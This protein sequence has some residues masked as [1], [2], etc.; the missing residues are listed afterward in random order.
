MLV[1][2][3]GTRL[4]EAIDDAGL[5][6]VRLAE[7]IGVRPNLVSLWVQEKSLPSTPNLARLVSVL[8]ADAGWLLLGD[9]RQE[10]DDVVARKVRQLGGDLIELVEIARESA[11]PPGVT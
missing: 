8:R 7:Q 6:Q 4:R 11:G 9:A 5:T 1:D 2:D 3:F 10:R